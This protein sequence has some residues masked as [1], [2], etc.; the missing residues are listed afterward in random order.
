MC[1]CVCVR[2]RVRE[3]L[4]TWKLKCHVTG[5]VHVELGGCVYVCRVSVCVR[6]AWTGLGSCDG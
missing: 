2:A 6:E 4:N 1:A 5:R 3:Q